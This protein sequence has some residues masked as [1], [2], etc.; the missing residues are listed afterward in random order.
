MPE[1]I[2]GPTQVRADDLDTKAVQNPFQM[3][4]VNARKFLIA[5]N[6]CE[7]AERRKD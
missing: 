1:K 3:V 2:L 6:P 4:I 7:P 5:A